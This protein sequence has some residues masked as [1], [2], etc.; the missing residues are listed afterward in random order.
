MSNWLTLKAFDAECMALSRALDTLNFDDWQRPTNC[1]PWNLHEL[2]IH[3]TFSI[4]VPPRFEAII[5]EG[6][7]ASAADY[8]R[9]PERESSEYKEQNVDRTQSIAAEVELG[10]ADRLFQDAWKHA[11]ST[12]VVCEP[13]QLIPLAAADSSIRWADE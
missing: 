1:P 8:F 5:S 7:P 10:E 4:G 2:V 3:I 12:F 13:D 9:R 11:T 6:K